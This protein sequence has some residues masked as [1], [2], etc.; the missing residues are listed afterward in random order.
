MA[1]NSRGFYDMY[2]RTW[3]A[4]AASDRLCKSS[5]SKRSPPAD[6]ESTAV[7]ILNLDPNYRLFIAN[8]RERLRLESI[9]LT[10]GVINAVSRG[11]YGPQQR[12]KGSSGETA[13]AEMLDSLGISYERE[14]SFDDL[15]HV[16]RLRFDF[17]LAASRLAIEYHGKQHFEPVLYFGGESTHKLSVIRDE[18]KRQWCA[19][20]GVN[21]V[22]IRYDD[23]IRSIIEQL[24]HGLLR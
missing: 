17:Y 24:A 19:E 10:Q 23:D 13:I 22:E 21:L 18:V 2:E 4:L 3:M 20:N 16:G 5:N 6:F 1:A 12:A 15:V 11:V 9:P 8:E 14:K 7:E